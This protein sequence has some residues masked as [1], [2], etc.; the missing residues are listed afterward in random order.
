MASSKVSTDPVLVAA[1]FHNR[2][3]SLEL[4]T[5]TE[6]N[7]EGSSDD[8]D[9][10]I[11]A[12][13]RKSSLIPPD[14]RTRSA[15]VSPKSPLKSSSHKPSSSRKHHFSS[16]DHH[17]M[18]MGGRGRRRQGSY[19]PALA[20]QLDSVAENDDIFDFDDQL[21][22]PWFKKKWARAFYIVSY[23]LSTV[24]VA[25]NS[26]K[27]FE[28]VHSLRYATLAVDV[29]L[30]FPFGLLIISE[31]RYRGLLKKKSRSRPFLKNLW[32]WADSLVYACVLGSIAL[33]ILWI[34]ESEPGRVHYANDARSL[35][36]VPRA[37]TVLLVFRF[38]K[39]KRP[40]EHTIK[41]IKRSAKQIR[42]AAILFAYIIFLF[43]LV[44]VQLF[45]QMNDHCVESSFSNY[46]SIGHSLVTPGNLS[47]PDTLCSSNINDRGYI[48]NFGFVFDHGPCHDHDSLKKLSCPD[49]FVCQHINSNKQEKIL[50]DFGNIY[51]AF[52]TV[53]DSSTQELW[54]F[55]MYDAS[56]FAG[57]YTGTIYFILLIILVGWLAENVFIVV[58]IEAFADFRSRLFER[59]APSAPV[60]T[61]T[62]VLKKHDDNDRGWTLES[63]ADPV[64]LNSPLKRFFISSREYH[65]CVVCLVLLDSVLM[66][67]RV[68]SDEPGLHDEVLFPIQI[69]FTAIF[70]IEV[71]LKVWAHGRKRYFSQRS[72]LFEFVIALGSVANVIQWGISGNNEP[73]YFSLFQVLRLFR[74]LRAST[75]LHQFVGQ[76]IGNGKRLGILLFAT[77]LVLF[78]A[79][80]LSLQAFC[81]FKNVTAFA[82]FPVAFMSTFQIIIQEG[83]VDLTSE[84]MSQTPGYVAYSASL[85][86]F[87]PLHLIASLI[88]FSMFVAVI[89]DNLELPED[90]KLEEQEQQSRMITKGSEELPWR[91]KI[92]E[93]FPYV[94]CW[95]CV[96]AN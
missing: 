75:A 16:S 6:R 31:V 8:T 24:S 44:G 38:G 1:R 13:R 36:L 91:L 79:G 49:N 10:G 72:T 4:P 48:N 73:H 25:C 96:L 63:L 94:W 88:I 58:V 78:I 64:K 71:V 15:S 28:E 22:A 81:H 77:L 85:L 14:E 59:Y 23:L 86:F 47:I 52:L 46:T 30:L 21:D 83:W 89:A 9:G 80:I 93:L 11:S 17:I 61:Q 50:G 19:V 45:G 7:R 18:S 43:A 57:W 34:I 62:H 69:S 51:S 2:K 39:F 26:P 29:L 3:S 90:K 87:L 41:I 42:N 74:L 68:V 92:F 82:T 5:L 65:W 54:A 20:K 95:I 12:G 33:Q 66:A 55:L 32:C 76:I 37:L 84:V 27:T 53:Y 56:D 40:S 70:L 67:C 35:V 60:Q